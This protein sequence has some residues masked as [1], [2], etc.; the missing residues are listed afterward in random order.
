MTLTTACTPRVVIIG[1]G[2]LG[3]Y[4]LVDGS[5]VA[6]RFVSTSH[7][8][9]TRYAASTDDNNDGTVLVLN[10]DYTVGGTQDART[11]TL[12]GSQAVLTS[13][14]RIV[15]ERVQSYTQDLDLTTGGSFNA[16]AVESRFDKVGEFQQ[17]LKARL[18]RMVPLQF[19][20]ATANVGFPS[21]PTSATKFLARNTSGEFVYA[22]AADLSVDVALGTDWETILG[23]PAAGTLDNL[24]GIRFVATYAALTA[25]ATATGLSDNSIYCTYARTTEEDGGFGFW[26]YDSGVSTTANGGT[27]LAIDGGGAGRFFRLYKG[28]IDPRWFGA[29]SSALAAANQTAFAAIPIGSSVDLN[30]ETYTVSDALTLEKRL[31]CFHGELKQ[32]TTRYAMGVLPKAWPASGP[33]SV[34]QNYGFHPYL[35]GLGYFAATN[36]R[37]RGE[38]YARRHAGDINAPLVVRVSYGGGRFEQPITVPVTADRQPGFFASGMLSATRFAIAFRETQANGTET[39]AKIFT[40]DA[41]DPIT[42]STYTTT[43]IT[44]VGVVSQSHG[45]LVLDDSA[46][47][48]FYGGGYINTAAT[49]AD[50]GI[51]QSRS[52][53]AIAGTPSFTTTVALSMTSVAEPWVVQTPSGFL[54][55]IRTETGGTPTYEPDSTVYTGGKLLLSRSPTGLPG[56]W[57]K[58]IDTGLDAGSNPP[59]AIA[60]HG[61]VYVVV[62]PRRDDPV[63][64]FADKLLVYDYLASDLYSATA[65]IDVPAPQV[66]FSSP[67]SI[68]GY[69]QVCRV[70][71]NQ[72]EYG[73]VAEETQG[74]PSYISGGTAPASAAQVSHAR[75]VTLGVDPMAS[76]DADIESPEILTHNPTF[77]LWQGGTSFSSITTGATTT[78]DRWQVHTDTGTLTVSR[79]DCSASETFVLPWA[80][81]YKMRIASTVNA[82]NIRVRQVFYGADQ[83]RRMCGRVVSFNAWAKGTSAAQTAGNG[84]RVILNFGTSGSPSPEIRAGLSFRQTQILAGHTWMS[85]YFSIPRFEEDDG[86]AIT[87]G[88]DGNA[89]FAFEWE[90]CMDAT[91]ATS[92]ELFGLWVNEGAVPVFP[93]F[94][95]PEITRQQIIGYR[96]VLRYSGTDKR[97]CIANFTS[98]SAGVGDLKWHQKLGVP[99]VSILTGSAGSFE[100]A[101]SVASDNTTFDSL[102][103]TGGEIVVASSAAFA[104]GVSYLTAT[105]AEILVYY[106]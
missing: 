14:Q 32:S 40:F 23:L 93:K 88:S 50:I 82:E 31:H 47:V 76:V 7:V 45:P 85:S 56:T 34:S 62:T 102:S 44:E 36:I 28:P 91:A 75:I 66:V 18:D 35:A 81:K 69:A 94:V 63:D 33:V 30:D 22:T 59:A 90:F 5:S 73:F 84:P 21:P 87:L 11:F 19:A 37:I 43:T 96:E 60:L 100:Q 61:R 72:V 77:Q 57:T 80:P 15:A 12:I 26:R 4:S 67:Y 70:G 86:T 78:C 97:V 39:A 2:T 74:G 16:E 54:M 46:G 106:E 3:P 51:V 24:A 65:A 49:D 83:L 13:S 95:D 41:T 103:E 105:D 25:L 48:S 27:I 79:Q 89:Y 29:T 98:T 38:W 42:S 17:E 1:N 55:F 64:G 10:V 104:A 20:D 53:N 52:T 9:L 58:P 71:P 92:F 8:R 101:G 68:L 6:I 99:S